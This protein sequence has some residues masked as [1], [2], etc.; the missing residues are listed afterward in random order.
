MLQQRYASREGFVS[1]K[2][3][4]AGTQLTLAIAMGF[5]LKILVDMQFAYILWLHGYM[6]YS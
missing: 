5:L 1:G 6:T 3:S 4:R 2:Q